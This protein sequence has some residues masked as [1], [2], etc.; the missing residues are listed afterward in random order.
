MK[1]LTSQDS[2]RANSRF[3]FWSFLTQ[4]RSRAVLKFLGTGSSWVNRM[5]S[6][7]QNAS[8]LVG[9]LLTS[10]GTVTG[11]LE[12]PDYTSRFTGEYRCCVL[13]LFFSQFEH[14]AW[15]HFYI[16]KVTEQAVKPVP[17]E[18]IPDPVKSARETKKTKKQKPPAKVHY[19]RFFFSLIF[20]FSGLG[21]ATMAIKCSSS[22]R[23]SP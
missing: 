8:V 22:D 9:I 18:I 11:V 12:S 14:G 21:T 19:S 23:N 20:I 4:D 17:R 10:Q 2:C 1:E 6:G 13:N 3:T 16:L 7:A 15:K 5:S